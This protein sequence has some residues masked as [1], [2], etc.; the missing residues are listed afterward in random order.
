M[1]GEAETTAETYLFDENAVGPT[2][3]RWTIPPYD[4]HLLRRAT[5]TTLNQ[6][7]VLRCAPP[8]SDHWD[9][10]GLKESGLVSVTQL[11]GL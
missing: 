10:V 5:E 11:C 8:F 4:C 9:Q 6:K 2:L 1:D 3:R 7:L